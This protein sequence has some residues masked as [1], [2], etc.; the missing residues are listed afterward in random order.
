MILHEI[1]ALPVLVPGLVKPFEL[2]V[3]TALFDVVQ[4][5]FEPLT[6]LLMLKS[7]L[8]P[9]KQVPEQSLLY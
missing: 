7:K 6:L 5:Y 8:F 3:A 2:T 4:E 9:V 1:V